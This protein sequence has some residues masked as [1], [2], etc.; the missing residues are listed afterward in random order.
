MGQLLSQNDAKM[1]KI[2]K[3]NEEDPLKGYILLQMTQNEFFKLCKECG[4]GDIFY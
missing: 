4:E 2:V 3:V 1:P